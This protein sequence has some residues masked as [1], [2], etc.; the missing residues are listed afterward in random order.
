MTVVWLCIWST[1]HICCV[2]LDRADTG[3]NSVTKQRHYTVYIPTYKPDYVDTFHPRLHKGWT[4]YI[5]RR[6]SPWLKSL[7]CDY[8]TR[9]GRLRRIVRRPHWWIFGNSI[10]SPI[11][12]WE[13]MKAVHLILVYLPSL[14]LCAEVENF[15]VI[16]LNLSVRAAPRCMVIVY[17]QSREGSRPSSG[18]T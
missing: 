11:D 6:K 1:S 12:L 14:A 7:F 8:A 10:L 9:C 4:Q 17:I 2:F 13:S 18:E 5:K 3:G 16:G 15:D